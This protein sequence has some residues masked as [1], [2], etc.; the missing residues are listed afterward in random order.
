M[1]TW[2]KNVGRGFVAVAGVWIGYLIVSFTLANSYE[3]ALTDA[4]EKLDVP[5]NR[6]PADVLARITDEH[7]VASLVGLPLLLAAPA[8]LMMAVVGVR[9]RWPC[10]LADWS[11]RSASVS[12][13]IWWC[14]ELI[15][16]GTYGE[17]G[18]LPPLT[19]DLDVLS[20][21]LVAAASAFG[22]I[23]VIAA[24][25][26]LRRA[27][28]VPRSA[29]AANAV[30]GLL[31]AAGVADTLLSGL[32]SPLPPI[33]LVPPALIVGIALLSDAREQSPVASARPILATSREE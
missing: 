21:P 5:D 13:G 27:G 33:A 31:L 14:Y 26:A 10:S 19:R 23:A 17:P 12:A 11:V 3:Q 24:T 28:C 30:A 16:L 32:D 29:K 6:L 8:V 15:S 2:T 20:V 9:R 18:N 7:T 1:D 25:E 4:A 22:L